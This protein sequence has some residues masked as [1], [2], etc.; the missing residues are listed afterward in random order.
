MQSYKKYKRVLVAE[1]EMEYLE[2]ARILSGLSSFEN[3]N[4]FIF[5][6]IWTYTK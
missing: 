6:Y 3:L 2:M 1:D 4:L 5:M